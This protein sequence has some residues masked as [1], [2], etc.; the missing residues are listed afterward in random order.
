MTWNCKFP[1]RP[2]PLPTMMNIYTVSEEELAGLEKIGQSSIQR[3]V[4]LRARALTGEHEPLTVMD[5]AKIRL[6]ADYWQGLIDA[7]ILS[8]QMPPTAKPKHKPVSESDALK[9]VIQDS[10]RLERQ[11]GMDGEAV[12]IQLNSIS[13]CLSDYRP[14]LEMVEAEAKDHHQRICSFE[15]TLTKVEKF[16]DRV[17]HKLDTQEA[18]I[19]SL[20]RERGF[21]SGV[22]RQ[23]P[24]QKSELDQLGEM[25][26]D[27]VDNVFS[28]LKMAMPA[29]GIYSAKGSA[30]PPSS[31]L[32]EYIPSK[33]D[34]RLDST[35][36]NSNTR[37]RSRQR[38]NKE[39]G[40]VTD[41]DRS[42]SPLPPKLQIFFRDPTK[43][44]WS[45]FIMQFER[46]AI[47]HSWSEAKKLDR[48]L[49]CLTEKALEFAFKC[50]M[51]D[52][53]LELKNQLKFR[54][55][56]SD[57]PV[58]PRQKLNTLKQEPDE[59]LEGFMRQVLNVATDGYRDFETTVLQQMAIDAFLIGCRNKESASLVLISTP[60]TIQEACQRLKTIVAN[61]KALEGPKV[62]FQERLFSAQ[63][64]KRVS[65][66]ERKVSQMTYMVR[67]KSPHRGYGSEG[68]CN[69][70]SD[71]RS[72]YRSPQRSLPER[73][74]HMSPDR[75]A[76]Y[77][78]HRYHR[79][80]SGNFSHSASGH[81][82]GC[83]PRGN[84]RYPSHSPSGG[85]QS[86]S[87]DRY[88][89][90]RESSPGRYPSPRR[91]SHTPER[92]REGQHPPGHGRYGEDHR[93]YN[94]GDRSSTY[95]HGSG[96]KPQRFEERAS[97][98]SQEW[99][100]PKDLNS[101]G[102]GVPAINS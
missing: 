92:Y 102:L 66:L 89:S 94:R 75:Y 63:A 27:I 81:F 91:Y 25:A 38:R 42:L 49:S 12:R 7:G 98:S 5:L 9:E 61:K 44:R 77:S 6:P 18:S 52:S 22:S 79:S 35:H 14:R 100:V 39:K 64:E 90:S 95:R 43:G 24:E 56:L 88:P 99:K 58:A 87:G 40:P 93:H 69:Y 97:G 16:M 28:C 73:Y 34:E 86:P 53:F 45:S 2:V 78:P 101:E 72:S 41:S 21:G 46:I 37:G 57:E 10:N 47:R 84:G 80:P 1:N 76:W 71:R 3:I 50:K 32:D 96:H 33:D 60:K 85:S 19:H 62:S 29:D 31:S 67:T 23:E 48:L 17:D 70:Y 83:P 4:E 65:D 68:D 82:A 15:E 59:T 51:N 26:E 74:P 11:I 36:G 55:D 20:D 13:N 8:I 54:F 30:V